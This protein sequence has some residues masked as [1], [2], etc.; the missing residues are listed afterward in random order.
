M[1][2]RV[3]I[4]P[5]RARDETEFLEAVERSRAVHHPWVQPPADSRSFRAYVAAARHPS[6]IPYV[7][8]LTDGGDI[9]GVVNASEIVRGVFQS[10]YLGFYAFAPWAGRGLMSEGLSLVL[11]ELFRKEGLH[12]V[13]A[14]IQPGNLSSKALARRLGFRKE[15][16]SPR[17]LKIGGRWRDHE[18][19]AL[20]AEEWKP[21]LAAR[22]RATS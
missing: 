4:R 12:R 15:G 1:K 18:R 22:R 6:F 7:L 17:Y 16:L 2:S 21:R 3:R 13:E 8:C 5:P 10:A 20:L 11:R 19:W 14:N 9:A